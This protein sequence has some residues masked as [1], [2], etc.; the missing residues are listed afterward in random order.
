MLAQMRRAAPANPVTLEQRKI[1][2]LWQNPACCTSQSP[3]QQYIDFEGN[4]KRE[5]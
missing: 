5:P 3:V 1:P 4:R 2:R